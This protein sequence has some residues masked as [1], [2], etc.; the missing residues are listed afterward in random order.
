VVIDNIYVTSKT[1]LIKLL[2]FCINFFSG[3]NCKYIYLKEHRRQANYVQKYL[4]VLGFEVKTG[5]KKTPWKYD[6]VST[7]GFA[8]DEIL[9]A[10]I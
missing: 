2:S 5:T 8:E 7:N 10:Y 4:S 9:E 6:W 1:D 3:N